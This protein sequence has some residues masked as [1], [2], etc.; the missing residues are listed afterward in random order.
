M[1][2]NNLIGLYALFAI[3]PFILIYLIR[4]KSFEKVIPSLMFIM[5]EKNKFRKAS[6]LQKLLRNL[7]FILQLLIISF[8]A[9]SVASPYIEIPHS[10][11]VRNNIIILDASASM[12]T[13]DGINTRFSN[14]VNKA[15]DNLGLRNT[16]ILAENMPLIVLEDGSSGN[17]LDILNKITPKATSTNL[18]DALLLA[19]DLLGNKKGVVTVISDF[20]S[21]EGSDLLIAKRSLT[22]KGN[23]VNFIDVGNKAENVGIT[24]IIAD[25]DETIVEIKNYKDKDISVAATLSKDNAKLS[26]KKVNLLANSKEKITFQTLQGISKI[27]LDIN[28][29]LQVD[30]I[31]YISSPE[32]RDI[33]VLLITNA[34][35]TSK[36][37][38][39][40][41]AL[42]VNLEIREPPTVN[43][44]NINH[45]LVVI[46]QI[47]NKLFVPT[48]FIDLKKYVEKGGIL[49]IAA[50]EN[51]IEIDTLDLLPLVIESKEDKTTTVCA[52]IIGIIFPKDPFADEPCFT[53]V[54]KYLKGTAKNN[55]IVLASA[56]LD[57]SP[58]IIQMKKEIGDVVYYGIIDKYSGFYSDPF[59]PIFW[60]NL[61][62]Y[63]M[64]LGDVR[65]YNQKSGKLLVINEQEVKTPST[66]IT[67]NKLLLDE[68]GIYEVDNK[69]VAVNLANE[70]ESDINREN[71]ELKAD[72]KKFS[73]EKLK[74]V[75]NVD[76]EIPLLIAALIILFFEFIYIKRRGDL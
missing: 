40:L 16:I 20:I 18:G 43:A 2:L 10:V 56:Q 38:A 51:L 60:N 55:T 26:D 41:T 63:L 61:V 8:L 70:I 13:K 24:D 65:D 33:S 31:A 32:K 68:A 28:D 5:Q 67:T 3:I 58:V 64:K 27:A 72:L 22:A 1:P 46:D 11:M 42:G 6:F 19:G 52:D 69:K 12:Q 17:A 21:T 34:P 7:L 66:K 39:A 44:Y 9:I 48:D 59:Y 30:N 75:D 15:K 36:I 14:A 25:K 74:D 49:V 47:T 73:T 76:L 29:D 45:D 54:S 62:A 37:K 57:N 4:P 35:E 50:Q 71:I 23:T 53:S